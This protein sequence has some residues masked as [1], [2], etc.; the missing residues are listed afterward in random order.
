MT[1]VQ[2]QVEQHVGIFDCNEHLVLSNE[3]IELS[4]V[5]KTQTEAIEAGYLN[6]RS[7][8]VEVGGIYNAALNTEI[9]VRVWRKIIAD[10]RFEKHAW[11]V[12]VDTDTVFFPER[13]REFLR[14]QG[15]AP[16]KAASFQ[17]C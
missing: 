10:R 8:T 14:S 3:V 11:T 16:D 9:F 13:L 4:H 1:L 15:S 2:Q 7:L 5:N 12:K 6:D 17:N